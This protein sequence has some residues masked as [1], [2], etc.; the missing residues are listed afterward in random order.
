MVLLP[1]CGCCGGDPCERRGLC[2]PAGEIP[3]SSND[4]LLSELV[5]EWKALPHHTPS[6]A[7]FSVEVD[8]EWHLTGTTTHYVPNIVWFDYGNPGGGGNLS[9]G[10]FMLG[11]DRLAPG[12]SDI[13]GGFDPDGKPLTF[14]ASIEIKGPSGPNTMWSINHRHIS[15]AF[16]FPYD[17]SWTS[18]LLQRR[19][20]DRIIEI[21]RGA[22]TEPYTGI[23]PP[24][25][26][27]TAA[28]VLADF[29]NIWPVPPTGTPP[30]FPDVTMGGSSTCEERWLVSE[31]WRGLPGIRYTA[32][33][34]EDLFTTPLVMVRDDAFCKS[35]MTI[36]FN[37]PRMLPD[38]G[39]C[40]PL[41]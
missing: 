19:S 35:T 40:N 10:V 37:D 7:Y 25:S 21:S 9:D 33:F 32:C 5:D 3:A 16:T 41:P 30:P 6:A 17:Q 20:S 2:P 38:K 29:Y 12:F 11:P 34:C 31:P 28:V 4:L 8:F 14:G 18:H 15:M 27:W 23:S 26:T 36:H 13:P 24:Y 22:T 1:G 39:L